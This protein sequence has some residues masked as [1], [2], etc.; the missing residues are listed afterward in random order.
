MINQQD[1]AHF[2]A[3]I[4]RANVPAGTMYWK[5]VEA[6]HADPNV[7]FGGNQ[8]VYIEALDEVGNKLRHVQAKVQQGAETHQ[9]SLDKNLNEPGTNWPLWKG[10]RVHVSMDAPSDGVGPLH[11]G[12][13]AYKG[14]DWHHHTWYLVF[15]RTIAR[16][17]GQGQGQ[18]QGTEAEPRAEEIRRAL[19]TQ[20]GRDFNPDAPLVRY[21]REHNLG[22]RPL[23]SEVSVENY[24]VQ[25]Y[26]GGIVYAPSDATHGAKH[27]EW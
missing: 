7:E 20:M 18:E 6:R 25:G 21:A 23:T 26:V 8:H 13:G 19:W 14:G 16:E 22:D 17:N 24:Q 27:I 15:Q 10:N 2:G 9:V 1:L 5:L 3:G 12:S 4:E 11:T